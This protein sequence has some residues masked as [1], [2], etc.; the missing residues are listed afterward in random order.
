MGTNHILIMIREGEKQKHCHEKHS[1]KR[2]LYR[3]PKLRIH[4]YSSRTFL[5]AYQMIVQAKINKKNKTKHRC[6]SSRCKFPLLNY[7]LQ[8]AL[9]WIYQ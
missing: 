1:I 2:L 4:T 5:K 3:R 9:L 7:I 6:F 8:M